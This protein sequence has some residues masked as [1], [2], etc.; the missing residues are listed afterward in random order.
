MD[1][2]D[3]YDGFDD[4]FDVHVRDSRR[5]VDVAKR[6]AHCRK[7]RAP[8]L[9]GSMRVGEP[10]MSQWG[11]ASQYAGRAPMPVKHGV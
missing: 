5:F 7:C 4:D 11:V 2:D 8:I 6:Q 9:K 10:Y 3:Y 1:W